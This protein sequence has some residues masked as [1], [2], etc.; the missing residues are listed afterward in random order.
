M[1]LQSENLMLRM[2]KPDDPEL[3]SLVQN[4]EEL[5][6][7]SEVRLYPEGMPKEIAFRIEKDG[8][9][10][11]E[12]RFKT[13]KWYNRKGELSIIFKKEFQ[14]KGYGKE[15][16]KTIMRYAFE[17]MNLH[18]LECEV[19]DYNEPSKK[20][21]ESLGFVLEGRLREGK[22]SDGKYYD[23]LRYGILRNEYEKEYNRINNND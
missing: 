15:V 18:R 5:Y 16:L 11:G 3:E 9:L 8:K 12:V 19:I 22:Y 6:N 20:L 2:T 4:A 13:V 21:V 17:K 1:I 23:V 7:M 14:H 10:I